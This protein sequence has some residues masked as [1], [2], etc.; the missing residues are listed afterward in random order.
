MMNRTLVPLQKL[1]FGDHKSPLNY[2]N[3]AMDVDIVDL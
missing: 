3:G 2:E 1:H